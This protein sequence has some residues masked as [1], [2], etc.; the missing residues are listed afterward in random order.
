MRNKSGTCSPKYL[1]LNVDLSIFSLKT[2]MDPLV[3]LDAENEFNIEKTHTHTRE[4]KLMFRP[5]SS[6]LFA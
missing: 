4:I 2:R 6:I 3:F 1:W 5:F